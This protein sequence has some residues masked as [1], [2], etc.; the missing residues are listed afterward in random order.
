MTSVNIK[1]FNIAIDKK[2][3]EAPAA[4]LAFKKKLV[5]DALTRLVERTPVGN[6]DLWKS[7][8]P[9]GYAGGRAR[10]NWQVTEGVP[11]SG[12]TET[13]DNNGGATIAD[14]SGK[15][16]AV[17]EPFGQIWLSNNVPYIEALE[18]G[19]STQAPNGMFAVTV[20]EIRGILGA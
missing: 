17:I 9:K 1:E 3:A 11:A 12:F 19:H 13:I 18:N 6:P 14:G 16:F 7:K 2:I 8:P 10:A 20:D 5:L 15:I 4:L